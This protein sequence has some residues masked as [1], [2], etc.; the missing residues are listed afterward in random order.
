MAWWKRAAEG[1]TLASFKGAGELD[2]FIGK[3]D[4]ISFRI[5]PHRH[6]VAL[7][8]VLTP[9]VAALVRSQAPDAV[10]RV[11]A[12]FDAL[13]ATWPLMGEERQVHYGEN[14]LDPPDLAMGAFAALAWLKEGR[15]G[16]LA[17]CVDLPFCRADL[18]YLRKLAITLETMGQ[19][20]K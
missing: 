4:A 1:G 15:P 8:H 2:P 12:V 19:S 7:F 16:E 9:E 20:S 5:A 14:Y 3:G 11:W 10:E 17:K 18:F 6:K 13:Y